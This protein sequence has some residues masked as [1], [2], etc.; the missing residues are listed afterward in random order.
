MANNDHTIYDQDHA[1]SQALVNKLTY[2]SPMLDSAMT[3]MREFSKKKQDGIV[4]TMKIKV[5]NRILSDVREIVAGDDTIGYLDPL[6]EDVLPQNSD[7]V[8]VLGQYHAA[9]E[10][11]RETHYQNKTNSPGYRQWITKEWIEKNGRLI[12]NR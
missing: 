8:L 11:F 9:L 7:A 3:E 10:T 2:I 12:K 4:S 5:L 6:D 1:P